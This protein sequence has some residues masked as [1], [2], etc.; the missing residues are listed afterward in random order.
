ML[1]MKIQL[2]KYLIITGGKNIWEGGGSEK[3]L[4][5]HCSDLPIGSTLLFRRI[6]LN[7]LLI[8]FFLNDQFFLSFSMDF[9]AASFILM[10]WTP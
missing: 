8:S 6:R 4:K 7:L 5:F 9:P 2:C 3:S 1:Q 10:T